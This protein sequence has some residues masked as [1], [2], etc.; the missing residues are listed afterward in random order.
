MPAFYEANI[1]TLNTKERSSCESQ[2]NLWH[3]SL[4]S[5]CRKGYYWGSNEKLLKNQKS[6]C[7]QLTLA[8]GI[9]ASGSKCTRNF[10]FLF[11]RKYQFKNCAFWGATNDEQGV[12]I[13][14]EL[15]VITLWVT[16]F[17]FYLLIKHSQLCFI[18]SVQFWFFLLSSVFNDLK[19]SHDFNHLM[20]VWLSSHTFC[21]TCLLHHVSLVPIS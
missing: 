9:F 3:C 8:A 17:T 12:S 13:M 18:Y 4:M 1:L 11:V 15:F 14:M 21:K 7:M 19:A 10:L 5:A 20:K 6:V 2:E 16:C